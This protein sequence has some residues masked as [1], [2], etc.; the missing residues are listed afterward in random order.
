MNNGVAV[1]LAMCVSISRTYFNFSEGASVIILRKLIFQAREA[2]AIKMQS[3]KTFRHVFW[4]QTPTFRRRP[5]PG[6]PGRKM[7]AARTVETSVRAHIK[8]T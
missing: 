8:T 7:E 2:L 6:Y 5:L 1:W 4:F 3:S